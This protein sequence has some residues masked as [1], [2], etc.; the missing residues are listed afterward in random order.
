MINRLRVWHLCVDALQLGVRLRARVCACVRLCV[1]ANALTRSRTHLREGLWWSWACFGGKNGLTW[2]GFEP[3]TCR[4][5]AKGSNPYATGQLGMWLQGEPAHALCAGGIP[6]LLMPREAQLWASIARKRCEM[7]RRRCFH[8]LLHQKP[9]IGVSSDRK[10]ISGIP[11]GVFVPH[12]DS[13]PRPAGLES[14]DL[15]SGPACRCRRGG[16]THLRAL[17]PRLGDPRALPRPPP[18]CCG[19]PRRGLQPRSPLWW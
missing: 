2:V 8:R 6:P 12:R 17:C 15:P 13:N 16:S 19:V 18:L 3:L 1:C 5:A 10:S 11:R 9:C 14:V 7:G 4:T